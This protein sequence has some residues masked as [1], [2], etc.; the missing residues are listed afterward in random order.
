M[1][2]FSF[3]LFFI[4]LIKSCTPAYKA[5][6]AEYAYASLSKIPN[7]SLDY[8][9]AAHPWKKDLSDSV[10]LPLRNEKQDSLADVFFIHPTTY[11][12]K[13]AEWNADIND[14]ELNTYTDYTTILFQSSV[15]NGHCRVFAPRYRQ[16]HIAAFFRTDSI[17]VAAF[18]T[19]YGDIKNAFLFYL[20]NYNKG[21]PIII[22]GHSQG[23]K[24]AER[25]LKEF[26]DSGSLQKQLVVAYIVGWP[27][28]INYFR[29]LKV[30]STA[31]Q[32]GCFCSWRTYRR[33]YV[34]AYILKEDPASY[35]TNPLNWKTDETYAGKELH[36]G[37]V[38]R[39][40]NKI[41]KHPNDAQIHQGVL[42]IRRPRFQGSLLYTSRNYHIGDI[43][44]F[45]MNL[46]QN[47]A[48]RINEFLK[49][50]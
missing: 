24:M 45:Y 17:T 12:S 18:D 22:A 34:P 10:P 31:E 32:T 7:Y 4:P 44:L 8:F 43:N 14:A 40:F 11:T 27:V 9:W 23:A 19:A 6:V 28:P 50:Q 26:F 49:K 29:E 16:A 3:F 30:C 5:H 1:L 42:W 13:R 47:I 20:Q 41:Y 37:S 39:N 35:V 33:D 15:F 36:K 48:L 21:R 2:R 46:R 25:L 38:L